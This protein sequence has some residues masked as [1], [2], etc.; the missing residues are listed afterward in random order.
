MMKFKLFLLSVGAVFA[1]TACTTKEGADV[2]QTAEAEDATIVSETGIPQECE[3]FITKY[4]ACIMPHIPAESVEEIMQAFA[5][6]RGTIAEQE[7]KKIM[8][9]T[10]RQMAEQMKESLESLGCEF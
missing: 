2:A 1:L 8:I 5:Q 3:N 4:E 9:E 7:D 6:M 10:C